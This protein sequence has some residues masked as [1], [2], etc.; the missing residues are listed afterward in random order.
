MCLSDNDVLKGVKALI[1]QDKIKWRD[2]AEDRMAERGL[3]KSQVKAC[4]LKGHFTE[5]PTISN[6]AGPIKY[7]FRMEATIEG[8]VI[9]VGAF[10]IPEEKVVVRT[11]FD[12]TN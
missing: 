3:D 10:L 8:Q 1:A 12:P 7:Q 9:A 6:S 4:L 5:R 11:L 2:H